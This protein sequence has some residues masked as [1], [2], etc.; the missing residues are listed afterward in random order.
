MSSS[1]TCLALSSRESGYYLSLA[2]EGDFGEHV[3][4]ACV[5]PSV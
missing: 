3:L 4:H 5:R 1:P 2:A